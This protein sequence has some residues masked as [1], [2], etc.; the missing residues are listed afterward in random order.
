MTEK[1]GRGSGRIAREW[2]TKGELA[3]MRDF[4]EGAHAIDTV[5]L[6]L[7]DPQA[8]TEAILVCGATSRRH[9]QGLATGLAALCREKGYEFL[10]MEGFD[11]GEWILLDCNNIIAHIFQEE[12]RRL[13]RLEDLW[14]DRARLRGDEDDTDTATD[15]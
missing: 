11:L 13:Y 1:K 5:S 6:E 9:A 10:G 8:I 3:Q 2:D 14:S 7:K 4:L 15:S 12:P